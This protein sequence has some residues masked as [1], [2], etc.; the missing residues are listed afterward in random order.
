[1]IVRIEADDSAYPAVLRERLDGEISPCLYVLGDTA[2]LTHCFLGLICSVQCPGGIILKTLD[3]VRLLRDAGIA[4]I[5]GFHAPMERECLDLLLRGTQ[6]VVYCAAR[7]LA[8]LRL[9]KEARAVLREGRLLAV[10]PFAEDVR[11]A[12]A[13][14]ALR[15]NALVANLARTLL[16]PY[17]V[18]GGKVWET[19]L[20]SLDRGQRVLTFADEENAAL[21]A[22]GAVPVAVQGLVDHCPSV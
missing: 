10:S 3:A 17:A 7:G 2:I 8:G 16:V 9:G 21:I 14:R 12:T 6:P 15:R 22:A 18:P 13:E 19:V 11:R 4:V 1:M 5:G 20:T